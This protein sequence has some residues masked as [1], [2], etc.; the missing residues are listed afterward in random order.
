MAMRG[1]EEQK[2]HNPT[3]RLGK[4]KRDSNETWYIHRC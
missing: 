4:C 3:P 1:R 2:K